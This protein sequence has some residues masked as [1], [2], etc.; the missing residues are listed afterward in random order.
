[1]QPQKYDVVVVG[2]GIGGLGVGALL[3]HRGYKTLV[4]EQMSMVGGRCSTEEVEGFK[5]PTGAVALHTGLGMAETFQEVGEEFEITMVPRLFYRLGG[6]DYEMATPGSLSMM[7]DLVGKTEVDR[8]QLV[9]VLV[10][11]APTEKINQS[12]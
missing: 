8:Q 5:L 7:L 12:S 6:K 4:V 2:S 1:M 11:A 10:K 9:G 3:A